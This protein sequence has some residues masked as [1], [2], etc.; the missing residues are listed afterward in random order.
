[1]V[2]GIGMSLY[3]VSVL[4]EK[5]HCDACPFKEIVPSF[6]WIEE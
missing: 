4:S 3:K 6:E 2:L 5:A 1:M